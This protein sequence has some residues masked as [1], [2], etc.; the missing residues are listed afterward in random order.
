MPTNAHRSAVSMERSLI[1]RLRRADFPPRRK[2]RGFQPRFH[3]PFGRG[4]QGNVEGKA[5]ARK[6]V[7]D[8]QDSRDGAIG[9]GV[10]GNIIGPNVPWVGRLETF[11]T[12]SATH[13]AASEPP[14]L[15]PMKPPQPP[16]ALLIDWAATAH[17]RADAAIAIAGVVRG[18]LLNLGQE[19]RI[20]P[21][22]PHNER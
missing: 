11:R 21:A 7:H 9:Q 22:G 6:L 15:E 3:E 12:R 14:H 13:L 19:R 20:V 10:L 2:R 16:D 18:L 17:Q 8:G 4:R 1:A 5:L